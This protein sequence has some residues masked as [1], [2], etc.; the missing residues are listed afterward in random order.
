MYIYI[1]IFTHIFIKPIHLSLNLFISAYHHHHQVVLFAWISLIV[2][3]IHPYHASLLAGILGCILC[4][5]RAGV[6]NSLLVHPRGGVHKKTTLM[7]SSMFFQQCPA[8][9]VC[10][11]GFERREVSGRKVIIFWPVTS[12]IR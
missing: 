11:G 6:I 5:Y 12:R 3:S 8:Y 2:T 9:L 7:S 1:C 4:P 10:L